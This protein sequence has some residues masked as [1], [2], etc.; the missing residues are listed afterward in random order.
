M[1]EYIKNIAAARAAD[2][3]IVLSW[4][5]PT[6]CGC[7]RVVFLHRLGGRDI[8]DVPP[9]ELG[10]VSDLCFMDEFQI[11]GGKYVYPIGGNDAGLLKFR[12]YCCDSPENIDFGKCSGTAQITGITL[13]ISYRTSAKKSG[14]K[15]KKVTFSVKADAA[16]SAGSLAYTVYNVNV[17]VPQGESELGPVILYAQD[18]AAL[19]LAA[20]HEDEYAITAQ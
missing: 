9:S 15:Y 4:A 3:N 18:E 10:G 19:E 16:V 6:G 20:G 5:W 14:K 12:V 17:P 1:D 11:A 7:V 8:S 2:G 13:N